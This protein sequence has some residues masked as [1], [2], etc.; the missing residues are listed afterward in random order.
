M[1]M[2]RVTITCSRCGKEFE[3]KKKCYNRSDANSFETWA[4]QHIDMCSDCER[5]LEYQQAAEETK[6][7]PTLEGSEKQIRWATVI[8]AEFGKKYPNFEKFTNDYKFICNHQVKAAWWIENQSDIVTAFG[9]I[10]RENNDIA[11]EYKT[12]I[13]SLYG[14]DIK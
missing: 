10:L 4:E 8:R 3:I 9:R 12:Y 13:A 11:N 7:L 2:A 1:A 14:T 6:D 5:E